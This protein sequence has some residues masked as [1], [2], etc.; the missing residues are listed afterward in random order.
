V[1]VMGCVCLC[2]CVYLQG[3][4]ARAKE[5]AALISK[6]MEELQRELQLELTRKVAEDFVNPVGPLNALTAACLAPT[7]K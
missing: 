5:I 7:S 1:H 6:K 4:S 2:V 3:G